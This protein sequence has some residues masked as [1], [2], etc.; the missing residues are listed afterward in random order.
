M[1]PNE[2]KQLL[3]SGKAILI[4]VREEEELRATGFAEAALWMPTSK[5]SEDHSDWLAFKAKL[6]KD[7]KII[8]YCRSGNRSG[9]IAEFLRCEGYDTENMGAFQAW[10]AAGL[11][12]SKLP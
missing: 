11:A 2:S 10:V 1:T 8:L 6:P 4:D 7:K 5:I 3:Q 12:V 9:R